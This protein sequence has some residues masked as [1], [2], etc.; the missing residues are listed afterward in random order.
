MSDDTRPVALVTGARRGIGRG[1]AEALAASGFDVVLHDLTL[2]AELNEAATA[3]EAAGGRAATVIGD[4]ADID[5][6]DSLLEATIG[7]FGRLDCL[8]N[9]AGVSV[10]SRGDLL[11][12]SAESFDRCL[13]VNTRGPFFLAQRFARYL[14]EEAPPTVGH[15]AI[16]VIT[17][18]NADV[19]S[20][21]RAEYCISKAGLAM[22]AQLFAVR[23]APEG[24]GVY[25]IRPGIIRTEMTA[26]AQAKYD[27]LFEAGGS[28]VPRW[29]TPQEVGQV[30]ATAASGGL[31]YTVGQVLR[32][33]GGVAIRRL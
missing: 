22:L 16:V 15:R 23:L 20:P 12:A 17:S 25:D 26:P 5:R 31:P 28:P 14:L 8:V 9:N 7:A 33:D 1:C 6:H 27:A 21:D 19:V 11:E 30:V 10:L 3:V 4:V 18:A 29:G 13:A 2:S 32:V 24:I